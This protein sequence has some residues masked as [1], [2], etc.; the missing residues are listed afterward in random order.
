M[1]SGEMTKLDEEE[2]STVLKTPC[3]KYA[4]M[5]EEEGMEPTTTPRI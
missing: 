5:D 4:M 3:Q 1:P 2:E